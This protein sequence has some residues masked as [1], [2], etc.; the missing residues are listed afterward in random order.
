MKSFQQL[1]FFSAVAA[2]VEDHSRV[3]QQ[4]QDL[5]V[6]ATGWGFTFTT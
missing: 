4:S 3:T 2:S 6:K 5:A 1:F